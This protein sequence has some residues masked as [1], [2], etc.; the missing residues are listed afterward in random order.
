MDMRVLAIVM[1]GLIGPANA[2][3]LRAGGLGAV[4]RLLPVLAAGFA[5]KQA[6]ALE[7]IPSLGS[8]GGLRALAEGALDIAVSGRPLNAGELK[9]GMRVVLAMRTPFVMVT[10]HPKPNGL[11][12]AEIA[13]VFRAEKSTW[14]DGSL[15]RVI[16]RPKSDSDTPILGGM[17]PGMASALESARTRQD[18]TVAATDQ[19]NADAAEQ[20]PGSLTGSTLTQ[21][22]TEQRPLRLL[23]ID[24]VTPS[25]EALDSGAYPFSKTIYFILPAKN[26]PSAEAFV[27]FL[28]SPAGQAI[29][30]DGGNLVIPDS[31]KS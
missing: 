19:D 9:Q 2:D 10:S 25:L 7:V 30:H 24:G 29:L 22:K 5:A 4:T 13:E 21:I 11:N 23:S 14:A 6:S 8:S 3:T 27:A 17:F 26:N 12:S 31:G 18:V 15:I 1:L 28:R 16:L 20:I